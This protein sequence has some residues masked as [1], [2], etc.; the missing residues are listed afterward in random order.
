MKDHQFEEINSSLSVIICLLALWLE[1]DWLFAIY[2]CKSI[3][4][5]WCAIKEGYK[6]AMREIK[7]EKSTSHDR[8]TEKQP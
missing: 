4:D 8:Q 3:F 5:I 1:I 7:E 6:D 2:L